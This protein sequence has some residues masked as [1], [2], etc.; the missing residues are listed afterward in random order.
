M[1]T[2][3]PL[4]SSPLWCHTPEPETIIAM[5]GT[6]EATRI[7]REIHKLKNSSRFKKLET[8][9]DFARD[10]ALIIFGPYVMLKSGRCGGSGEKNNQLLK[11]DESKL[12]EI[13][14]IVKKQYKGSDMWDALKIR[15]KISAHCGRMRRKQ[16]SGK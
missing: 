16:Q 3:S 15:E 10:F 7:A 1:C 4:Q 8:A 14:H 2:S 9:P 11:L 6:P 13:E 12:L 5:Q